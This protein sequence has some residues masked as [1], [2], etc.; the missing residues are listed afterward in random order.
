[1][2]P[3][4]FED[5]IMSRPGHPGR[6][7]ARALPV[8]LVFHGL[9]VGAVIALPALTT[10]LPPVQA[11]MPSG[12]VYCPR[13]PV[14]AIAAPQ[15]PPALPR[16]SADTR[17]RLARPEN[18]APVRATGTGSAVPTDISNATGDPVADDAPPLCFANCTG[19]DPASGVILPTGAEGDG[20]GSDPPIRRAGRDVTPPAKLSGSSPVYPPLPKQAGVQGDVVIECTID[21]SGRVVNAT[22]TKSIPLL[23]QAALEAVVGWRYRPTLVD[24]VPVP[25]LMTVTVRFRIR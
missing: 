4:M 14:V 19:G 5:L 10:E 2:P 21:P 15:P 12:P 16:R 11:G 9:A 1:M 7:R 18:T 22:V 13:M 25:V 24:G 3:R 20:D 8:S 6:G 23:D 17:P